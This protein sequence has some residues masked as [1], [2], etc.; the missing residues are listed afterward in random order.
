MVKVELPW[1]VWMIILDQP[2]LKGL[3]VILRLV[4][5]QWR[6]YIKT[7]ETHYSYMTYSIRLI[8]FAMSQLGFPSREVCRATAT[9]G[10]MKVMEW[11]VR[12]GY[13][14]GDTTLI[15]VAITGYL[16]IMKF[17]YK[18][19]YK[20]NMWPVLCA[21]ENGHLEM[22]RWMYEKDP[23]LVIN[24]NVMR[25]AASGGKRDIIQFLR[26]NGC[27][28]DWAIPCIVARC[29]HLELLKWM[30]EEGCPFDSFT[31]AGA[32]EGGNLDILKWLRS[33]GCEWGPWTI[34]HAAREGHFEMMVWAWENG[35]EWNPKLNGYCRRMAD[36]KCL[37]WILSHQ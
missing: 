31:C 37:D 15:N 13:H 26:E 27:E 10:N 12:T 17:L 3:S 5:R 35:C 28:W 32:A 18:L 11:A 23:A 8:T 36:K 25:Q 19:G 33:Q 9:S 29:G 7:R 4:C 24:I 20:W 14:V 16:E 30:K 6:D 22:I 34:A 2:E 21:A 1:D